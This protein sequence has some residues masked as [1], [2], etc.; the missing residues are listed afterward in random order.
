[1]SGNNSRLAGRLGRWGRRL[2][3]L[4]LSLLL[5]GLIGL[6][7]AQILLRNIFSVGMLWADGLTRLLVLWLAVIGA[8][9]AA[10]DGRHMAIDLA[11]RYLP[12][13]G[14]RLAKAAVD[15][16]AA[17]VAAMLAWQALRFVADSR[18]FGDVLLSGWPAWMLQSV[19]PLG[20]A[21]IASLFALQAATAL[22][23]RE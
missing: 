12:G 14:K 4:L 7:F 3:S 11:S 5:A 22:F 1:L 6:G 13:P 9:A 8:V 17:I 15:S 18:E 23:G 16:F 2:E 21:L 10:R 19:M 20:F